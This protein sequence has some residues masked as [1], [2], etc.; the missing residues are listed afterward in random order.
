MTFA[1]SEPA[2]LIRAWRDGTEQ[3]LVAGLRAGRVEAFTEFMR[4]FQHLVDRYARRFGV[5][6]A[7][8]KHWVAELLH[9]VALTLARGRVY[10]RG[11]LTAYLIG[12]C[13][14]KARQMM[15]AERARAAYEL[16]GLRELG[17]LGERAVAALC[18]E[19]SMRDS[20]GPDWNP[21]LLSAPLERLVSALDEGVTQEERQLLVWRGQLVSYSQMAQWLGTSRG[22]VKAKV[23][24]LVVRLIDV[25]LR[26]GATLDLEDRREILRF[27]RRS[28][29]VDEERLALLEVS[30]GRVAEP[31]TPPAIVPTAD[32]AQT[33]ISDEGD[34]HDAA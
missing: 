10:A 28:E 20:H 13:A 23:R 24:R 31:G 1:D 8:R 7:D 14:K 27:L 22:A 2:G 29:A 12:A 6:A 16:E 18:S 3:E 21:P 4:R 34:S 17:G 25:S 9:D 19:G 5:P 26:F 32:P 15:R 33:P 11:S 30:T